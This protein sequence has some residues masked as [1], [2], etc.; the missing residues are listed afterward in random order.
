MKYG[1]LIN[2]KLTRWNMSSELPRIDGSQASP[3]AFQNNEIAK[4]NKN[5]L[6]KF[7]ENLNQKLVETKYFDRSSV[8]QTLR[9]KIVT[10][11]GEID[12][13]NKEAT[14]KNKPLDT[15]KLRLYI[16]KAETVAKDLLKMNKGMSTEAM[17]AAKDA[18]ESESIKSQIATPTQ[19][20]KTSP[21]T[22][23]QPSPMA[24]PDG[25][26]EASPRVSPKAVTS[27]PFNANTLQVTVLQI[28]KLFPGLIGDGSNN[29]EQHLSDLKKGFEALLNEVIDEHKTNSDSKI[30]IYNNSAAMLKHDVQVAKRSEQFI[31]K[32]ADQIKEIYPNDYKE[33]AFKLKED[34]DILQSNWYLKIR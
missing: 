30:D 14:S 28:M 7:F 5:I 2:N 17:I 25:T 6:E 11:Q 19:S 1:V 24:S 18:A 22:S 32:F 31:K 33:K 29:F 15:A 12:K 13:M 10:F 34:L 3:I 21:S 27:P 4:T 16:T 8:N 9:E 20:P 26:P 23:T